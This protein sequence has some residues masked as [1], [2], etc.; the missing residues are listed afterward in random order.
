MAMIAGLVMKCSS[1]GP[2]AGDEASTAASTAASAVAAAAS[3]GCSASSLPV[4]SLPKTPDI[5]RS[6]TAELCILLATARSATLTAGTPSAGPTTIAAATGMLSSALSTH[7]SS[8][9]TAR[10]MPTASR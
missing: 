5:H 1:A 8:D 3:S 6:R 2:R 10:G 9:V 4:L 7:S